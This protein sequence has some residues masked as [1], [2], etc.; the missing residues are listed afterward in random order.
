M[1]INRFLFTLGFLASCNHVT[2]LNNELSDVKKSPGDFIESLGKLTRTGGPIERTSNPKA[3]DIYWQ[4]S[5]LIEHSFLSEARGRIGVLCLH[6][7]WND[8]TEHALSIVDTIQ[9]FFGRDSLVTLR[10]LENP[11]LTFTLK[12]VQDSIRM[13]NWRGRFVLDDS[14]L[15]CFQN[16]HLGGNPSYFVINRSGH[17]FS[18]DI[19]YLPTAALIAKLI[20]SVKN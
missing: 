15:R 2:G 5:L 4:D 11:S 14:G 18:S 9:N 3:S 19:G 6:E 10:V 20:D 1:R 7:I 16:Y 13:H 8:Q 17:I 12:N